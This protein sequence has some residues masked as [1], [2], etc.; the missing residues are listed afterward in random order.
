MLV[1]VASIH[2]APGTTALAVGLATA[3]TE[4]AGRAA[5]LVEA[6]P[7]G[8]VLAA[9]HEELR[10]HRTLADLVVA[11]R[12]G[13]DAAA[14]EALSQKLWDSV[15]VIPAPPSAEQVTAALTTGTD[16]LG[17]ALGSL[18]GLDVVVDVGRLTKRSPATALARAADRTLLV[19]R[20]AFESVAA[21]ATRVG[22]LRSL[23]IEPALVCVGAEPYD[24]DDVAAAADAELLAVIPHDSR[25]AQ[26]L[27]GGPGRDRRVRRSGLWRAT[28]NLARVLADTA[29]AVTIDQMASPDA[30]VAAGERVR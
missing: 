8:G 17:T 29:P 11:V 2:G 15:P 28:T 30:D 6:D 23:G 3:W 9:R 26:V 10:A 16:R 18:A 27:A 21:A 1:A 7:D 19:V 20:P 22:E 13:V 25:T 12:R 14:V 24:P 4:V 5:V